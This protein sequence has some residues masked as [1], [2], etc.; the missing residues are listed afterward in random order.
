MTLHRR[1]CILAAAAL[2][3]GRFGWAADAPWPTR[4]IRFVTGGVGGV[5]DVRLRWLAE[6]LG[7]ALGQP[8]VVD[9][10]PAGGGSVSAEQVARSAPDGYTLLMTHQ[11]IAAITPHVSPRL[12]YDPIADFAPVTRLG[13]GPLL[14]AVPASVPATTLG[15]LLALAR[16]QPGALNYGSPGLATPP[17]LAGALFA[18][19][20]AIDATHVPFKGGGALATALIG[21]QI[22]W[23]IEGPTVLLPHVRSG[24]LRALGVTGA[25]RLPMIPDVPTIA[26]AGVPGYEFAGWTGIVA[27]AAT[28]AAIVARLNAEIVRIAEAPEGRQWFEALAAEPGTQTPEAFGAF[29]REEHA[30]WGRVIREAGIRA[31]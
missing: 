13:H 3:F 2:S 21:G 6:R 5:T 20:A 24:R 26:E 12:G 10:V 4:P 22:T 29:V 18:R 27:P 14:L 19:S 28:P 15:E 17:H 25:K 30:K 1:T 8:I 23:A 7:P 9:N 16:R 31:E 11:G